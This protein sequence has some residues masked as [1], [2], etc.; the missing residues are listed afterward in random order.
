M[1]DEAVFSNEKFEIFILSKNIFKFKPKANVEFDV[2]DAYEIRKIFIGLAEGS[3]WAVLADGENY[4]STTSEFRQL[5]ASK[6]YTD[7]RL[8]LAIVTRSMATKI[9]G[10]FFI[11]VN[12]PGSPTKLFTN[13][14]EAYIWLKNIALSLQ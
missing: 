3:K 10:N 8:A 5:A 4:F 2:Q 6:E 1:I 14:T 13:E 12:K 11:K 9:I 7:N